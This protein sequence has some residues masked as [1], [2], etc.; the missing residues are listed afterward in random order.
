MTPHAPHTPAGA[1][2]LYFL[3]R[4]LIG[5]R[6]SAWLCA[7]LALGLGL[8]S[9][10]S[11]GLLGLVTAVFMVLDPPSRRWFRRWEPYAGVLVAAAV[12][13]PV[14]IWNAQHEWASFVFP[15]GATSD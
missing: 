10:Y 12:F 5:A 1:A 7:G 4:A 2:S 13:S 11:I 15:D 9:K 14:V 8:I 3:E 6:P